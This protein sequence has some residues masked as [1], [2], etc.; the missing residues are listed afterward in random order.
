MLTFT[1][2]TKPDR[3]LNRDLLAELS[4][5]HNKLNI[6]LHVTN[7]SGKET[8]YNIDYVISCTSI[9]NIHIVCVDGIRL[10]SN[11]ASKMVLEMVN[12]LQ[13]IIL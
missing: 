13:A 11:T 1:L 9:D 7:V 5:C 12:G 4:S 6:K 8:M 2:F 3:S 10:V